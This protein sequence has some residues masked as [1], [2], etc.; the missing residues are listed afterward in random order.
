MIALVVGSELHEKATVPRDSS[1]VEALVNSAVSFHS[2]YI[3]FEHG[4]RIK[5]LM[6][7]ILFLL[8]MYIEYFFILNPI[9]MVRGCTSNHLVFHV[10]KQ[11][12]YVHTIV[13]ELEATCMYLLTLNN[14]YWVGR[15]L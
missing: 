13:L 6:H 3:L 5:H 2:L 8:Y 1:I 11:G 7:H 15:G 9:R 4:P 10:F 14:Y 12:A